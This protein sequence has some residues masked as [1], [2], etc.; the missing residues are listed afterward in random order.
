MKELK[1][2]HDIHGGRSEIRYGT[3]YLFI[4]VVMSKGFQAPFAIL[5]DMGVEEIALHPGKW[6]PT[7]AFLREITLSDMYNIETIELQY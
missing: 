6:K 1:E 4:D 5:Y 3:Q 7:P 2:M